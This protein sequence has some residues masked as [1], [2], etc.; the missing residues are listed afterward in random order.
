MSIS[1][2][3]ANAHPS[4]ITG[5]HPF[6]TGF[7]AQPR[8]TIKCSKAPSTLKW[9][10]TALTCVGGGGRSWRAGGRRSRGVDGRWWKGAD[11]RRLKGVD[12]RRCRGAD[13]R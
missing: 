1:Y 12:G 10:S 4:L 9:T 8:L 2:T 5:T 7:H 6:Q 3:L 11:G 13:G